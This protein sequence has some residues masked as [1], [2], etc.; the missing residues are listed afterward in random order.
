MIVD[1]WVCERTILWDGTSWVQN[2]NAV[3]GSY[4]ARL[5]TPWSGD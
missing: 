3:W 1:S 5:N 2:P 4:D